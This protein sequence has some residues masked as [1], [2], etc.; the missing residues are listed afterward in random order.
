MNWSVYSAASVPSRGENTKG[1]GRVVLGRRRYLEGALEV[2]VGFTGESNDDV[3]ADGQ[4]V[5]TVL[6]RGESFEVTLS[7]VPAMHRLEDRVA[8]RLQRQV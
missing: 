5:D 6:C 2:V 7:G 4:V 3:G 1:I 8:P